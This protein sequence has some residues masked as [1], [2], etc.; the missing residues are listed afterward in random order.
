MTRAQYDAIMH[1]AEYGPHT[2]AGFLNVRPQTMIAL[3]RRG[4]VHALA[5]TVTITDAG[6][7]AVEA[8]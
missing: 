8:L 3:I 5:G 6:W 7:S 4:W 2:E 1:I